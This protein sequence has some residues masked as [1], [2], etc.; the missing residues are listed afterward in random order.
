MTKPILYVLII[1]SMAISFQSD[2]TIVTDGIITKTELKNTQKHSIGNGNK[3]FVKKDGNILYIA[4]K[5]DKNF[6]AHVYLTNSELLKVMHASAAIDAVEYSRK[7]CVWTTTDSFKYEIR[8]TIYDDHVD[9]VMSKYLSANGWVA[10]NVNLGDGRTIEFK[11]NLDQWEGELYFAC[12]LANF[13]M[14]FYPFPSKLKDDT[15]L[16]RLVQG[17]TPDSLNFETSKWSR[18]K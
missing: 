13:D 4:L 3:V 17:Y 7:G 16:P 8:D 5:G 12:V 9:S 1:I 15:V 10:N 14:T 6:W 2:Q 11:I 18:I